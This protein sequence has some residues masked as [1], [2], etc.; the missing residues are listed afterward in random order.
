M[1]PRTAENTLHKLATGYPIL[2]ITGPRQSGKTT[3]ARAMFDAL[4]Y[5][6]LENPAQRQF[7]QDDPQGFLNQY[8]DGAVIDEVQR[9]PDLFAWL[10]GI[11]DQQPRPGRFV[12]TGSQQ[13]GLLSGITQSLAGRVALLSLLP[14]TSGELIQAGQLP[15]ALDNA[16]F[17]GSY[18]PI[19]DRGLDPGI[20]YG[21][22]VQTYLERD[23]RQLI[24]VRDL[25]QFQR[26]LRLCAGR[27]GQLLNL[28]ALGEEAGLSH[29]TAREW[30][31][32][33]EASY[34]L[35]RLP[36]H[37]R[38]FNK[39]LVKTPKLYFIDTGLACWLLGIESAAQ[40]TTH[41]LRGALLETWVVAEY[42]KR[43]LNTARP[44]NLSFWRDR[45]GHEIDL[46]IEQGGVLQPVEIKS[47]ATVRTEALSG[48]VKWQEISGQTEPRPRLVYGGD[49]AQHRSD[50]DV[51]AWRSLGLP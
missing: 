14:F 32:V 9:C 16:L 10:Q 31:S 23:V 41:P 6:S 44:S 36:P 30:V 51:V 15:D 47:G 40:V 3:L 28:S 18:P 34:I 27:T 13:F 38:N 4:P 24:N 49:E 22:Y 20:W 39:R 19:F 43:R 12:L 50:V 48:L 26:F 11:V 8:A 45:S 42:L 17:T 25:V 7:A 33:L 46:L 2:A 37:H 29:N 35:H 21:N 1:I 5:V